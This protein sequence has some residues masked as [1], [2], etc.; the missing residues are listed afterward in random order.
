MAIFSKTAEGDP[1]ERGKVFTW[2]RDK[3]VWL[4]S[5]AFLLFSVLIHGSGFYLFKV[6]YPSPVRVEP[7]PHGIL[8][9]EPSDPGSRAVLQ[10]LTDRTV[11][12]LPPSAESDVRMRLDAR[13][14]H[15]TP[16][17][18]REELK[19][20]PPPVLEKGPG[21]IEPLPRPAADGELMAP[22]L[23][24]KVKLDPDLSHRKFAP[25]SILHD[26]LALAE[27]MPLARFAI[28]IA[29]EGSVRVTG[30]DAPMG[31][32]EKRELA[33]VVESTL[34]FVPAS[35]TSIGWIEAGGD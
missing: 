1:D 28:E 26:Y 33:S 9:V 7:R 10:R 24:A 35:E 22:A 29:P 5:T 19:L 11:Y 34:R 20:L 31:E 23:A 3:R 2:A 4:H 16:D 8:V 15:F 14:V 25:W 21:L 18:Q 12:L 6:V 27:A 30:V 32:P 17:F 13:R